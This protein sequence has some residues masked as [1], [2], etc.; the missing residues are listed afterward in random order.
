MSPLRAAWP[1]CGRR[2]PLISLRPVLVAWY[3]C[4]FCLRAKQ[5]QSALPRKMHN[6]LL[7]AKKSNTHIGI[8]TIN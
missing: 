1:L 3:F 8:R 4:A 7:N 5:E 2:L 6:K